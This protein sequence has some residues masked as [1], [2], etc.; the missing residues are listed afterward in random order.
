MRHCH[1]DGCYLHFILETEYAF[2]FFKHP[3]NSVLKGFITNPH[4]ISPETLYKMDKKNVDPF[5]I[6]PM[7]SVYNKFRNKNLILRIA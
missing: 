1:T 3:P 2:F 6:G 7:P 5:S 4:F